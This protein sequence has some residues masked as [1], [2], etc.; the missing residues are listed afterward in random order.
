MVLFLGGSSIYSVF[1]LW[2]AMLL[3]KRVRYMFKIHS[4]E[5]K[6]K[7]KVDMILIIMLIKA[8]KHPKD[9]VLVSTCLKALYI[10]IP[11]HFHARPLK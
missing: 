8:L 4:L 10:Y 9:F 11:F 7:A 2:H 6:I 5:E 1:V 3:S